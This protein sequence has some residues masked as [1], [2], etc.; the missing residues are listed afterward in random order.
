MTDSVKRKT[1]RKSMT[2]SVSQAH[3]GDRAGRH[4]EIGRRP[5]LFQMG[6]LRGAE[7]LYSHVNTL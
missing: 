6:R 5:I 7:Y 2:S 3:E 1:T 4:H